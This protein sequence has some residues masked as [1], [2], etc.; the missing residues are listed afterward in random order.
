MRTLDNFPQI[1]PVLS[2]K[3]ADRDQMRQTKGTE[4][5]TT[6]RK[7]DRGHNGFGRRDKEP[8]RWRGALMTMYDDV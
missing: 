7:V 1:I 4:G 8:A 3:E 5:E 2:I 6:E